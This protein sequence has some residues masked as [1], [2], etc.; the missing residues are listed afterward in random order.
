MC[1]L[2]I[3]RFGL[4]DARLIRNLVLPVQAG[5][6]FANLLHSLVGK[7]HRIGTHVSDE[8]DAALADVQTFIQLLREPH[9]AP[10]IE[11]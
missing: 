5:G 9:S 11:S 10:R 2:R 8:T 6:D 4:V 1:F 7:R 3:L